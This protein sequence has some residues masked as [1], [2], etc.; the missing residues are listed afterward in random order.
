MAEKKKVVKKVV[1]KVAIAKPHGPHDP[2]VRE[3][4]GL[5]K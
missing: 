3:A 1:K 4:L 2:D 5:D